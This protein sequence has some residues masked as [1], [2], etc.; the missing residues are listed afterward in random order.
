M[1]DMDKCLIFNKSL[2]NREIDKELIYFERNDSHAREN[3]IIIMKAST[4]SFL[5]NV[6]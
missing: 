5:I 2:T 3:W 6:F 4:K 1:N